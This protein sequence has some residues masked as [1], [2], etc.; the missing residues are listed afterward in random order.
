M[1]WPDTIASSSI[2]GT[3]GFAKIGQLFQ[4]AF[5]TIGLTIFLPNYSAPSFWVRL[6]YQNF[7]IKTMTKLRYNSLNILHYS[8]IKFKYKY[9]KFISSQERVFFVPI[10]KT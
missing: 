10:L 5:A 2:E 1:G 8:S 6:K 7:P 4:G 3:F 9:F